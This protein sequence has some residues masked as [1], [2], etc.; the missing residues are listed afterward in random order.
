MI[1]VSVR[2]FF[3]KGGFVSFYMEPPLAG[4][5]VWLVTAFFAAAASERLLLEKFCNILAKQYGAFPLRTDVLL[6]A[7]KNA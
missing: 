1:T 6:N 5:S 7:G 2:A 3:P 4:I